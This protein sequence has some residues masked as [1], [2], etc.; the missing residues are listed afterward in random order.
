MEATQAIP[1]TG[2]AGDGVLVVVQNNEDRSLTITAL[3]SVVEA[4]LGYDKGEILNRKLEIILGKALGEM[5]ADDLEFSPDAP[6]F[7]EL[8]ARVREIK[9]RRRNGD[10]IRVAMNTTRLLA[11]GRDACFQL[12][13]PSEHERVKNSRLREFI[14]LNLEGRKEIDEAT[15]LPN[16]K[17]AKEFLPVLKNFVQAEAANIVFVVLRIDRFDKS[18]ARYGKSAC[19]EL[20]RQ[21]HQICHTTFRSQD[22]MFALSDQSIGVVL[23]DISRDSARVVLNRLRWKVKSYRFP[24]GGKA[25][26]SIS[27]SIAFDMLDL[28]TDAVLERCERAVATLDAGERNALVELNAA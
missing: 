14:S 12:V 19:V 6:D 20:L 3:N 17:T 23:F 9:L 7:G 10:E 1:A 5:L 11:Q 8:F 16:H 2:R 22:L 15:G 27:T 26:F 13:I 28:E 4:L 24:F 18:V 25:D 21:T